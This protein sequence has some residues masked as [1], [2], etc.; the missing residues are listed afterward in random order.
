MASTLLNL[1]LHEGKNKK[2]EQE[3]NDAEP[4][5]QSPQLAKINSEA[6]NRTKPG[7]KF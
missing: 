1:E 5:F 3:I 4:K 2:T 6:R 7:K